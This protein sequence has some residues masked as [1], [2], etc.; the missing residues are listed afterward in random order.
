MIL[1]KNTVN[2]QRE[3]VKFVQHFTGRTLGPC[4][5]FAYF[6][7]RIRKANILKIFNIFVLLN[8]FSMKPKNILICPSICFSLKGL[9]IKSDTKEIDIKN[10]WKNLNLIDI[11]FFMW[12]L[13]IRL[14]TFYIY[15]WQADCP[16]LPRII[17][18]QV[19]HG[20]RIPPHGI[21]LWFYLILPVEF[22]K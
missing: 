15:Y 6:C 18:A 4:S 14:K 3:K 1:K 8:I 10:K 2:R 5:F 19:T 16:A 13:S 9:L 17:Y 20:R 12:S 21:T 7:R 11:I 22:Q